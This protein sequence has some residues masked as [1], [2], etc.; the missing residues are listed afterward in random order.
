MPI[1]CRTF[2]EPGCLHTTAI[3]C[4]YRL[5][6]DGAVIEAFWVGGMPVPLGESTDLQPCSGAVRAQVVPMGPCPMDAGANSD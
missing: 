1:L 2:P 6:T 5:A 3:D 4:L